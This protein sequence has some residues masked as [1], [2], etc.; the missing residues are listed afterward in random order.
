MNFMKKINADHLEPVALSFDPNQIY[1]L[2][3]ARILVVRKM[4]YQSNDL[5]WL[6]LKW[7][8]V[9]ENVAIHFA[10]HGIA[11]RKCVERN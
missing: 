2:L 1:R 7:M 3:L 8:M 4:E 6:H 5:N 9:G 11:I 10:V